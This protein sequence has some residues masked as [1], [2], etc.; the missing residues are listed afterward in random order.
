MAESIMEEQQT[1]VVG[2]EATPADAEQNV[3]ELERIASTVGGGALVVFGASR[4]S[5]G[6][7]AIALA[8]GYLAWRG[9]TGY[10]PAYEAI[11]VTTIEDSEG[12]LG[13]LLGADGVEVRRSVTINRP[14]EEVYAYWHDFSNLPK[15]MRQVESIR[16]LSSTLTHWVV[17]APFGTTVE[18]DAEIIN[19]HP[20]E[21][22]AWQSADYSDIAHAGLVRFRPNA[23]GTEVEVRVN[24]R[25]PFRQ[26]GVML[27]KLMGEDP[28]TQLEE[29]LWN[30]KQILE[31]GALATGDSVKADPTGYAGPA[32][33]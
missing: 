18:W 13:R 25:A 28:A 30:L 3:G 33:E 7:A 2:T 29:D 11:G 14:T 12:A 20:G 4:R 19:D 26:L 23:E 27:A 8:G 31:K 9:L 1:S 22:I 32:E 10:C 21:A 15:F 17:K 24:Y 6:G 16:K 5:L